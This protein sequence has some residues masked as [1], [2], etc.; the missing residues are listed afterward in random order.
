MT[1]LHDDQFDTDADLMRQLL[2]DQ[3][4]HG[5]GLGAPAPDLCPAN[6]LFDGASRADYLA[7][8]GTT[9]TPRGGGPAAGS[10][11]PP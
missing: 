6:W 7:T 8:V 2:A 5:L 9:S 3:A 1:R 4:S 10:S 11:R